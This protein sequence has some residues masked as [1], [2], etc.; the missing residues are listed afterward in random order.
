MPSEDFR[1]QLR[2]RERRPV[3]VEGD[4]PTVEEGVEVHGE[5][6]AVVDIETLLVR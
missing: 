1:G 5:K 3:A 6:E 4:Q 2:A